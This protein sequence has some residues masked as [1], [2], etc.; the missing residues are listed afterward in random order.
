MSSQVYCSVSDVEKVLGL[1]LGYFTESSVPP[2]ATV[3][4]LIEY[5]TKYIEWRTGFAWREVVANE[6]RLEYHTVG[7]IAPRGSWFVWLGYPIF[8]RHRKVRPFDKSKG[9]VFEFYNWSTWEDWLTTR[10]EGLDGDYW[11][12]Y[13][14][15][16]IYLRGL[17]AYLGIR[18][19][20]VRVRYRYGEETV[21]EDVKLACACLVAAHLIETTDRLFILPEGGT[22]IVSATRKVEEFKAL[23]DDVIARRKEIFMP[24]S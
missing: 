4:T 13:D 24:G 3:E 1:P 10:R 14:N 16:I 21:P 5:Y 9:D 19:F 18:E 17:W 12:D 20:S 8:L 11:V 6:G 7:R 15:G 2:R 22:N 23:A